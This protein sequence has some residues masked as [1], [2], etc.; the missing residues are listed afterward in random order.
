MLYYFIIYCFDLSG[1]PPNCAWQIHIQH[2]ATK[3]KNVAIDCYNMQPNIKRDNRE[4]TITQPN[5]QRG[6]KKLY[7]IATQRLTM[8]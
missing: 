5:I 4:S 2:V 1:W 6:K 7:I 8:Q 3:K